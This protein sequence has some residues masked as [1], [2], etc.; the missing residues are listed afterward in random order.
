MIFCRPATV[1]G[2]TP[3][4]NNKQAAPKNL[5]KQKGGLFSKLGQFLKLGHKKNHDHGSTS[6]EAMYAFIEFPK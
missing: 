5:A 3:K 6:E 4:A 2:S 1:D